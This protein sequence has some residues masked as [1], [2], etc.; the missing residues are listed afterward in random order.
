MGW[1]DPY[2]KKLL[3]RTP[4]A[5][6][7]ACEAVLGGKPIPLPE[8]LLDHGRLLAVSVWGQ[9]ANKVTADWPEPLVR[10]MDVEERYAL[11]NIP[12]RFEPEMTTYCLEGFVIVQAFIAPAEQLSDGTCRRV[13]TGRHVVQYDPVSYGTIPSRPTFFIKLGSTEPQEAVTSFLNFALGTR[14]KNWNYQTFYA[15]GDL[16]A[17]RVWSREAPEE[18]LKNM[19]FYFNRRFGDN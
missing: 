11:V 1:F 19:T 16:V 17:V 10:Q 9:W 14:G 6:Q 4:P 13:I 8:R 7:Q 5:F 15:N 12:R 18:R 2:W 3:L